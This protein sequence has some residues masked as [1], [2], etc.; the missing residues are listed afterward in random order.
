[1]LILLGVDRAGRVD[2]LDSR[3]DCKQK[4]TK[5]VEE[6]EKVAGAIYLDTQFIAC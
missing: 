5:S 4:E 3:R 6:I 1:M 2:D